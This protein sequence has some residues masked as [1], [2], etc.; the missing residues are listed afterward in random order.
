MVNLFIYTSLYLSLFFEVFLLI[1]YLEKR[2]H[3]K[4]E[5]EDR[6]IE[7]YPSVTVIVP[8]F[9]EE[10]TIGGT[11]Q[12]ILDLDYPKEKLNIIIVDDG[13][14]DNTFAVAKTFENNN[15][16]KVFHK[17][18]GGK[19]TALNFALEQTTTDLV[20]CLDADS[21]VDKMALKRML[22]YFDNE[23]IMA[24]TP[25]IKVHNAKSIIQLVQ[26]VE[27]VWAILIKKMFSYM[28]A[29]YVTPG[30][31]SIF[32]TEV[33]KKLGL[34]KHAYNTEDLEMAVRMQ[35][36]HY[37]IANSHTSYVYTVTP[38]TLKALYKQRLRW[39]YGFLKNSVDYKHLFFSKKHGNLGLF[40]LP[41]ATI[42]IFTALYF[43]GNF[44]YLIAN[45][46]VEKV[47][48]IQT[49]GLNF[50]FSKFFHFDWFF[51]NTEPI[52]IISLILLVTTIILILLSK[53]MVDGKIRFSLDLVYFLCLYAFIAPLWLGK[54]LY[55]VA[56]SVTTTWR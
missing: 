19:Y 21:F 28:D 16:I 40:I 13:S 44:L 46:L 38:K 41:V 18:N 29:I 32:R 50:N 4:K 47:I 11:V 36:N 34:Y 3:M 52:A 20:G 9:N 24:V 55:N 1:T 7:N 42:S 53:K 17:E 33:F 43:I 39:T 31:F 48:K 5:S 51:V 54:A 26:R 35:N 37:K 12:S 8:C 45:S 10:K 14:K 56:F 30:P 6:V 22:Q 27:Y 49:I 25:S 15:Q 23:E 2:P